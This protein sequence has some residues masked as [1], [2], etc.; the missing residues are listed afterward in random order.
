[1]IEEKQIDLKPC[2]FCKG[3]AEL[4]D[5]TDRAYG[6]NGY[7]IKCKCGCHLR[8]VIPTEQYWRDGKFS[9]P[10]TERA[11]RMALYGLVKLWQRESYNEGSDNLAIKI[12]AEIQKEIE[13]ALDSNYKAR[14]ERVDK[15]KDPNIYIGDDFV[16]ICDGKISALRGIDDF[17]NELREKYR[18]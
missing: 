6:F 7:E 18:G 3:T 2:P 17:I 5:L 10:I 11:K 4:I 1:M 14:Q 12:L 8:S 15:W 13:L 16:A 9:T